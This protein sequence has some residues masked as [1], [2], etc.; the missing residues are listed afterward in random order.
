MDQAHRIQNLCDF[1]RYAILVISVFSKGEPNYVCVVQMFLT[2][3]MMSEN[4]RRY[5]HLC[6]T[7][8]FYVGVR[9]LKS[10]RRY[11]LCYLTRVP[12]WPWDAG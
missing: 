6:G 3:L 12:S 5:D 11:S 7:M 8:Q 4:Q 1:T 9:F 2:S 10:E